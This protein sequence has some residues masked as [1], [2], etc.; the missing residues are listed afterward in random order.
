M[1]NT[2]PIT[3]HKRR[4]HNEGSIHKRK[5]GRWVSA[6]TVEG[7]RRKYYYG[8]TRE[9]A[10]SKLKA[11]MAAYSK[12]QAPSTNERLTIGQFLV[13][14]LSETAKPTVRPSTYRGY[15]G[16]IRTHILPELANTR[17]VK[18]TPQK[19]EA[20]LNEKRASGLSPQT[21]QHLRAILRAALSDAV[22]WGL[23]TQNV[24]A[25]VDGPRVPHRDVQPL[26]ADE[27]HSLLDAAKT[28]RLGALFS[29]ALAVG[30]RQGEALGLSWTDL[31]LDSGTLSVRKTL[32]RVDGDFVFVEPKTARSRRTIAV[33]SVAIA[34]VRTHRAR[35]MEERLA[36]GPLW[37]DSGLVFTTATGRP[38]QGSN[39]TRAFQQLLARAGLRRQRF[40]DLRHSCASLLLAQGVHPRVVMETLGHSQIALTMNTYSHVLPPLQ[41]E[42]AA[43][44][45]EVLAR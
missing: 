32:Q 10:S 8:R 40:H 21:V 9:E 5:D 16:K 36:A 33:P 19:L 15:E 39:V 13:D 22:K 6:M 44:M 25:L 42:A 35:Q 4:G 23:V 43:R 14:W 26:S 28:H 1:A 18:L 3:A 45:D 31:D 11:A 27:A 7:L 37:E 24:G 34:A 29:V 17:L 12:G 2:R 41:R 38:L 20:F 30:L